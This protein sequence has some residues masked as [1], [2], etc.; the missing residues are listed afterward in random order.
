[1]DWGAAVGEVC[2]WAAGSAALKWAA[3]T[4]SVGGFC[5]YLAYKTIKWW[6][7]SSFPER[8]GPE[9]RPQNSSSPGSTL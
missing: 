8:P 6:R 5:G 1:M 2:K 7:N 4:V 9:S 3:L